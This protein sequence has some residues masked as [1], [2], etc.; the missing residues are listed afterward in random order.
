MVLSRAIGI[1]EVEGDGDGIAGHAAV[2][3]MDGQRVSG[4]SI[5]VAPPRRLLERHRC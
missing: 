3:G 1:G 2:D 5:S 4:S